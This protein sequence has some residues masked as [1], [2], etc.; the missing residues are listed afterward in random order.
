MLYCWL[1][2]LFQFQY[3]AIKSAPVGAVLLALQLFQFQY[4]AIKSE[5]LPEPIKSF[6]VS[7]PIWCD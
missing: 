7:I 4:G 5:P 1:P 6:N 2:T 3:G